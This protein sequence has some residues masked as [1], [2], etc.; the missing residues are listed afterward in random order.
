MERERI[1]AVSF[2]GLTDWSGDVS[3]LPLRIAGLLSD[4]ENDRLDAAHAVTYRLFQ[5]G[6]VATAAVRAVPLLVE[7]ALAP[8]TRDRHLTLNLL[9][10]MLTSSPENR[11]DALGTGAGPAPS[12]VALES[13]AAI[14]AGRDDYLGLLSETDPR[15]RGAAATLAAFCATEAAGAASVA[16]AIAAALPAEE[17]A[18]ALASELCAFGLASRRAGAASIEAL[19]AYASSKHVLVRAATAVATLASSDREQE[20]IGAARAAAEAG[21]APLFEPTTFPWASGDPGLL[22]SEALSYSTRRLRP[23]KQGVAWTA[24]EKQAIESL[25]T[26]IESRLPHRDVEALRVTAAD[27]MMAEASGGP[28]PVEY[29][30]PA[31]DLQ[32]AYSLEALAKHLL[33]I[34]FDDRAGKPVVS[35]MEE[36]LPEQ[37]E[38]V[39]F[40]IRGKLPAHYSRFGLPPSVAELAAFLAR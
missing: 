31:D 32:K 21:A 22:A 8:A 5:Q 38:L 12:E 30:P 16:R 24:L 29:E 25:K 9:R 40:A 11:E 6:T 39:R 20:V 36:L 26:I 14:R 35:S 23:Q 7:I 1:A 19:S 2:D 15:A 3:A 28:I 17:D 4:D 18:V 10:W 33:E 34:G 27:V 13:A 37:V